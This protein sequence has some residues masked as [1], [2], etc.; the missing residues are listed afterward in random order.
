MPT[1]N[2]PDEITDLE[3]GNDKVFYSD[4]SGVVTEL[5]LGAADT[6]LTSAGTTSAPTWETPAGGDTLSFT[7]NGALTAGNA[8]SLDADGKVS[9]AANTL[10][11][12][13]IG[14]TPFTAYDATSYFIQ[15]GN[16]DQAYDVVNNVHVSWGQDWNGA[17]WGGFEIRCITSNASNNTFVIQ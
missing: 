9:A 1:V 13:A 16:N 14:S 7:A 8:A 4:S 6:V 15:V 3:A 11:G 2:G 10:A 12:N 17:A 5:A